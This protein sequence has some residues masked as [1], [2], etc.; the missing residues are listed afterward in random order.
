MTTRWTTLVAAWGQAHR[1]V[2]PRAL[3]VTVARLRAL[4]RATLVEATTGATLIEA[5]LGATAAMGVPALSSSPS[6]TLTFHS[7]P[8]VDS[9]PAP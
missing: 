7:R 2:T 9:S 6:R 8:S 5:T 1:I 3:Q 4:L